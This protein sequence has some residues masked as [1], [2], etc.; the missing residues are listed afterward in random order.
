MKGGGCD[1]AGRARLGLVR[2]KDVL[3]QPLSKVT[4]LHKFTQL[5]ISGLLRIREI[6]A[7]KCVLESSTVYFFGVDYNWKNLYNKF[8]F[9][10][11]IY[12][13]GLIS[14]IESIFKLCEMWLAG[15]SGSYRVSTAW[16]P[17]AYTWSVTAW[18][19]TSR[20]TLPRMWPVSTA[21]QVRKMQIAWCTV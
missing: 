20:A 16:K 8:V 18:G 12:F 9:I 2:K 6:R 3:T 17:Q 21:L 5:M 13:I 19:H 14:Y 7:R 4:V 1:A 11:N 10:H 15:S